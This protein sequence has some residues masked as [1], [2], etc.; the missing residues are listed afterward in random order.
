VRPVI[1]PADTFR[2]WMFSDD[3]QY[4]NGA[5]NIAVV[6]RWSDG[7]VLANGMNY[8]LG[9]YDLKGNLAHHVDRNVAPRRPTPDEIERQL[10]SLSQT[11]M[12]NTPS[13]LAQT[14][15]RLEARPVRWFSHTGGPRSDGTG[16]MWVMVNYGDSTAADVYHGAQLL[17]RI[18]FD[19]PGFTNRWDVSGSWLVMLCMPR[20]PEAM[21]DAEVRRWRIEG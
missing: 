17:G 6:G 21:H 13:R 5:D 18:P 20:E 4:P 14:R 1:S 2:V 11:P 8:R 10:A 9:L 7:V 16:R 12:G 3:D 19:C 15:S